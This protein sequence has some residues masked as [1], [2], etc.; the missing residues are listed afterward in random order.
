[1][2][3]N[4]V[5][6]IHALGRDR[7]DDR[8]NAERHALVDLAFDAGSEPKRRDRDAARSKNGFTSGTKPRM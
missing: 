4:L 3:F 8:G 6:Q 1:M 5:G 7:G 2:A